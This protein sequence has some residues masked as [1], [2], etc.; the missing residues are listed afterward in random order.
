MPLCRQLEHFRAHKYL[1]STH[2]L[3]SPASYQ[4]LGAR[5]IVV[6]EKRSCC[7]RTEYL[8]PTS[9]A[10][11]VAV[12]LRGLLRHWRLRGT[13]EHDG[14]SLLDAPCLLLKSGR[15]TSVSHA[16]QL[17]CIEPG[18]LKT[19]SHLAVNVQVA[20]IPVETV[21]QVLERELEPPGLAKRLAGD[22]PGINTKCRNRG[23][24]REHQQVSD[25]SS[26]A[27][28]IDPPFPS[29]MP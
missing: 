19:D 24:I 25:A 8:L 12:D 2:F 17:S 13:R 3:P 7:P 16:P 10:V 18:D 14:L 29:F 6:P 1:D 23:L 5:C 9:D 21:L 15:R 4:S 20:R 27:D 26:L 28:Q 22:D 11:Q